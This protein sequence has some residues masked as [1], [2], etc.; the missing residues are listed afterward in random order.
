MSGRPAPRYAETG[1]AFEYAQREEASVAVEGKLPG[2]REAAPLVV[3][4]GDLRA[5]G[6]PLHRPPE[7][8]GGEHYGEVLGVGIAADAEAP[9]HQLR[10][11]ADPLRRQAARRRKKPAHVVHPLAGRVHGEHAAPCIV[12][13]EKSARLDRIADEALAAH[14]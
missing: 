9:A 4:E 10:D 11:H 1:T 12:T 5:R 13:R 2:E 7:L 14:G 3:R 6:D 8:L